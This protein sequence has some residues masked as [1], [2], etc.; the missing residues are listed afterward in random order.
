MALNF[1][2]WSPSSFTSLAF[3]AKLTHKKRECVTST[4][5]TSHKGKT[6]CATHHVFLDAWL[7]HVVWLSFD[8]DVT[9]L[10]VTLWMSSAEFCAMMAV[11][12]CIVYWSHRTC[13]LTLTLV[14]VR[15]SLY[16]DG[17]HPM[18]TY[19]MGANSCM[20]TC[21]WI[22]MYMNKWWRTKSS[23]LLNTLCLQN[24]QHQT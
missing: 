5:N 15:P 21:S 16:V 13:E 2:R 7:V 20:H 10:S 18:Y 12:G 8:G 22:C 9:R 3:W 4:H 14:T 19:F 11:V 23:V 24:R 6:K 17:P 1:A